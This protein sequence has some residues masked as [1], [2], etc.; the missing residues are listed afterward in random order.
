M[1]DVIHFLR[2]QSQKKFWDQHKQFWEPKNDGTIVLYTVFGL[3]ERSPISR[4]FMN[5]KIAKRDVPY[6]EKE[7]MNE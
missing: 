4:E 6:R 1:S 2:K 5:D 7:A 3:K